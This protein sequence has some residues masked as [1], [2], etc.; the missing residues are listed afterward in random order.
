M[1]HSEKTRALA[2]FSSRV[3]LLAHE[4]TAGMPSAASW[5]SWCA[6]SLVGPVRVDDDTPEFQSSLSAAADPLDEK[7]TVDCETA[8]RLLLKH[9]GWLADCTQKVNGEV[10]RMADGTVTQPRQALIV[11]LF[12]AAHRLESAARSSAALACAFFSAVAKRPRHR[13]SEHQRIHT[14]LRQVVLGAVTLQFTANAMLSASL[15]QGPRPAAPDCQDLSLEVRQ[16]LQPGMGQVS[17][18]ALISIC[19][20]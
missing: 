7:T 13:A 6:S 18:P 12:H 15:L 10:A 8:R 19:T 9:Q 5:W 4:V 20:Q 2:S 3:L 1:F 11:E 16:A 14:E 17:P